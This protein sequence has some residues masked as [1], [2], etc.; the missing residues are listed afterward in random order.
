MLPHNNNTGITPCNGAC[1]RAMLSCS[2]LGEIPEPGPLLQAGRKG[3]L[4]S[5][6]HPETR[7]KDGEE[8]EKYKT[9][10]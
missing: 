10:L 6:C 3:K 5:V 8:V 7:D 1:G 9:Q 2:G 4:K